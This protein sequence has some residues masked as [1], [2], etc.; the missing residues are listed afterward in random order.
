M[1]GGSRGSTTLDERPNLIDDNIYINIALTRLI[2]SPALGVDFE[3]VV[4]FLRSP[5]TC[6]S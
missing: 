4:Y 5:E 2:K 6:P 3:L 1:V